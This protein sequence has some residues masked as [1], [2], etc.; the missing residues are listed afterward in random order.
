MNPGHELGL[1]AVTCAYAVVL[2]ALV[3]FVVLMSNRQKRLERRRRALVDR[4]PT[5]GD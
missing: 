3:V 2:A 4:Q 5:K 1:I